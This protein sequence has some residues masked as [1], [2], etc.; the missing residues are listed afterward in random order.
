[1]DDLTEAWLDTELAGCALADDR[2]T[3]RL[4]KVLAQVGGAMGQSIP[5]A[6]Q[7]WANTKAAY[8]FFSND[9]VS[10]ADVL[11]GH[12]LSTRDRIAAHS[13]ASTCATAH[14]RICCTTPSPAR[15]WA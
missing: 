15:C 6:C 3:R 12:F 7:D 4:R 8:R 5:L 13:N 14:S 9:R 10:E 2:L 11:A 1:M